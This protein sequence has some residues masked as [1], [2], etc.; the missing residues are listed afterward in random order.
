[1]LFERRSCASR[2]TSQRGSYI[3]FPHLCFFSVCGIRMSNQDPKARGL[4]Y[5]ARMRYLKSRDGRRKSGL[6]LDTN[7]S[8]N[9]YLSTP[10]QCDPKVLTPPP[11]VETRSHAF[12][13]AYWRY[14]AKPVM[15]S[16]ENAFSP[17]KQREVSPSKDRLVKKRR[18]ILAKNKIREIQRRA[19]LF[20]RKTETKE[21]GDNDVESGEGSGDEDKDSSGLDD[22]LAQLSLQAPVVSSSPSSS[23]AIGRS[24]R[25]S[26]NSLDSKTSNQHL[27]AGPAINNPTLGIRQDEAVNPPSSSHDTH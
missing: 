6:Q 12:K 1:M 7:D 18:D 21:S 23:A 15:E 27:Q 17:A 26:S 20:R 10:E 25:T 8:D 5:A 24:E 16:I 4:I 19:D 13:Q 14:H 11:E 3:P 9:L 2:S 22:D